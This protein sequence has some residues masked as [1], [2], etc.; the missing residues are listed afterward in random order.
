[1]CY[2]L[3]PHWV[4]KIKE[5]QKVE[6]PQILNSDFQRSL[7]ISKKEAK[8]PHSLDGEHS[9]TEIKQENL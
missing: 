1:M 3:T 6:V 7:T 2:F 9:R 5:A 8:N 4:Q